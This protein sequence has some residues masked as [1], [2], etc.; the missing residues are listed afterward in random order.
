MLVSVLGSQVSEAV[1]F[2]VGAVSVRVTGMVCG[3]LLA[4]DALIVIAVL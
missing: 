1:P 2:V 3:L 4:P